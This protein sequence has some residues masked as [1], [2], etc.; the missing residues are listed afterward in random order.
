[1]PSRALVTG[2]TGFIGSAICRHLVERGHAV[3][4]LHRPHSSLQALE[5]LA[6]ERVVGDI[7][8]PETLKPAMQGVD[9][10]FHAA[11]EAAHWRNPES[12]SQVNI[13]GTRNVARAA[14]EAGVKRLVYTSSIAA[15]GL[16]PEDRPLT[17]E[18][19]FNLDP[20]RFPYGYA[21]QQAERAARRESGG[22]LALVVLN[23]SIV[24][25]AG[26]VNQI[27]GT[28]VIE[29]ARGHIPFYP[30]GGTNFVHI[31]D[32]AAGHLAAAER[33]RPGERYILGGENLSY[34]RLLTTL[35][36]VTGSAPPM[37]R[38][39]PWLSGPAAWLTAFY[40]RLVGVRIDPNLIRLSRYRLYC[41][42]SKAALELG[43]EDA[44]PFRKAAQEAYEWYRAQ[45]VLE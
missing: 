22:D 14:A 45:G 15:L 37:I 8:Q 34:R 18:D 9:W 42:R 40:G 26:D 30:V 33:G 32:V 39:P 43:L 11:A 20:E 41:D 12:V 25:G 36:E 4:A 29:S 23:P 21:K 19:S 13:Q 2:S 17:E 3:R 1:L 27:S 10:V 24:L 31:D 16:P 5:G 28:L 35:A 6:L 7:M 38:I 44:R